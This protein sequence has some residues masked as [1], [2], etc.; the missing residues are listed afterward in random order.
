M[1]PSTT[2]ANNDP[3]DGVVRGWP[4][5]YRII[6]L[7]GRLGVPVRPVRSGSEADDGLAA[8]A[9]PAEV[10]QYLASGG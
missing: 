7:A 10:V 4:R 6:P 1:R 9:A 3:H 5:S 2:H 8:Q